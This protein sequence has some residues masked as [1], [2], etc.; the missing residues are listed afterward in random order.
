VNQLLVLDSRDDRR[1]LHGLLHRLPPK[2]RLEFLEWCCKQ[3]PPAAKLPVP[4]VWKMR[5]TVEQAYRCEKAN[6]VLSNE[7]YCDLLQLFNVYHLDAMKTALELTALVRR[8]RV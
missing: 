5:A 4:A 2:R 1:E 3:V 8:L 7:I 6:E